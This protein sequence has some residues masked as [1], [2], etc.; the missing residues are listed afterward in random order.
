MGSVLG[1]PDGT[2]L[3][4]RAGTCFNCKAETSVQPY[5]S[6]WLYS[7]NPPDLIWEACRPCIRC[8]LPGPVRD[9]SRPLIRFNS[10]DMGL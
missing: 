1:F 2:D 10:N 9:S 7:L 5:L 6:V 4:P 8:M 3:S